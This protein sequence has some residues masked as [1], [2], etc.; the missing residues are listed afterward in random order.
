MGEGRLDLAGVL[1]TCG[2]KV[3]AGGPGGAYEEPGGAEE[4]P[5]GAEEEPGGAEE[6][7]GGAEE[8]SLGGDVESGGV[9]VSSRGAEVG[10]VEASSLLPPLL[11][12]GPAY[13][14]PSFLSIKAL[15]SMLEG[16]QGLLIRSGENAYL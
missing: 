7:P 5:G 14:P 16:I 15:K 6:G 9:E 3:G 1:N 11:P 8:G 10:L 13:L 2:L 4:E 12:G